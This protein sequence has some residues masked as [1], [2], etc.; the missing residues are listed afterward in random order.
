M[1]WLTSDALRQILPRCPARTLASYE[2]HLADAMIEFQITSPL[3]A[4]AFIAQ[5][6]HE[7]A[8]FTR[9]IERANG[10][11]YEGR[12][13][14]GNTHPGDGPRYRGRGP[15]QLTGRANYR[16]AGL[17]LGVDLEGHPNMAIWADT[18]F[19]IAGWFWTLGA[20]ERLSS[21]ARLH[22]GAR[23]A[24]LNLNDAADERDFTGITFAINGGLNGLAQRMAYYHQALQAFQPGAAEVA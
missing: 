16:A 17:A 12:L 13:D 7:S 2:P 11:A 18:G 9:W 22:F 10:D 1:I 6:A 21:A 3:R 24:T 19:R 15:I 23:S 8:E 20:R 4:A 14:L 5:L